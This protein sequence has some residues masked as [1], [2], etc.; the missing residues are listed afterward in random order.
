MGNTIAPSLTTLRDHT[1]STSR[2]LQALGTLAP[3][4]R[5]FEIVD[6]ALF[7]SPAAGSWEGTAAELERKLTGDSSK[8]RREAAR[9][10]SFP[11]ACGTYLGRL[12]KLY[13]QRFESQHT[14]KG[15]QWTINPP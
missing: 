13:P 14:R 12:H 9:L 1:F 3:E 2:N 7:D 6:A 4:A 15:N 8:L 11:L 5:L 10:F